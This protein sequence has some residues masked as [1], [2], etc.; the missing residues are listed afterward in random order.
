MDKGLTGRYY[1]FTQ[2][3]KLKGDVKQMFI[4]DY[5]LWITKEVNGIQKMHKDA[6]FVFWRFVPFPQE[7]KEK[8]KNKGYYYNE[9]YVKEENYKL[10]QGY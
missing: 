4:K 7:I 10:S 2:E 1:E 8:L 6:R 9:L 3:N 5:L